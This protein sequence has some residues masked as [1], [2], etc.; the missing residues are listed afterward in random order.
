MSWGEE[1]TLEK[2]IQNVIKKSI[3]SDTNTPLDS[4]ILTKY[5]TLVNTLSSI[6]TNVSNTNT[7]V[8][9]SVKGMVKSIQ[10]GIVGK[11]GTSDV[12]VTISSVTPS[13][14]IVIINGGVAASYYN[15]GGS[16]VGTHAYVSS[17]SAT[18]LAIGG[19]V[20]Q[21]NGADVWYGSTISWQVIEFV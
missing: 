17:L 18:T 8:T 9:N 15:F 2:Y 4:S 21:Y 14:C 11:S 1:K 7:N 3:N 20:C 13:R 12:S 10:R 16:F 19:G 6:N 5:T